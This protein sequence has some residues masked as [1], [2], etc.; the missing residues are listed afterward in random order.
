MES[1]TRARDV[2]VARIR[3]ARPRRSSQPSRRCG[4]PTVARCPC[5]VSQSVPHDGHAEAIATPRGRT[6]TVWF[7]GSRP[8]TYNCQRHA[9]ECLP[10]LLWCRGFSSILTVP[11]VGATRAL[12]SSSNCCQGGQI[13][14]HDTHRDVPPTSGI[15][16]SALMEGCPHQRANSPACRAA[17]R[18]LRTAVVAR[19]LPRRTA[20]TH[21][22]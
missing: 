1:E 14:A 20:P 21:R 5:P 9:H 11:G 22:P 3:P 12:T 13:Y 10:V 15:S 19:G 8:R 7:V 17:S 6:A 18:T 4:S 16:V 2:G